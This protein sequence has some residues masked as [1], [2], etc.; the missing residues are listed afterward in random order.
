MN[1]HDLSTLA[2]HLQGVICQREAEL[3]LEQA[4]RGLDSLSEVELQAL[5][6]CG[7]ACLYDVARE[8][9]Y[10]STKGRKLSHRARCDLAV[11]PKGRPLQ[12]DG[13][14]PDLFSAP[15]QAPP[16]EALWL[17]IKAAW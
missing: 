12:L 17:E 11:T 16:Q 4:V 2:D 6:A 5:L 7:L 13:R 8:A 1:R 9:H 14:P 15:D 10:P 3:R